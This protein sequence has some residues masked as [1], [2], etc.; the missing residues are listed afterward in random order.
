MTGRYLPR[1]R[2]GGDSVRHLTIAVLL[3]LATAPA[4]QELAPAQTILFE[5]GRPDRDTREFALAPSGYRDYAADGAFVVGA[6]DAARDWPYVQPGPHDAWAGSRRH[7]S[8]VLFG[9]SVAEAG[10]QGPAGEA[11]LTL[12]LLDVQGGGRTAIEV[13]VNGRSAGREIM[14]R[15][16][17]GGPGINGALEKVTPLAVRVRFPASSP[18]T[19][20]RPA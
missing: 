11:E 8:R 7:S 10:Q 13:T 14:P 16:A 3:V 5:I 1:F 20:R 18:R 15:G 17:A 6:S 19:F 2:R 9:L 12:S 4:A